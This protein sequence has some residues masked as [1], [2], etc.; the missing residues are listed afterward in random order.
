MKNIFRSLVTF[1]FLN[2]L[3]GIN[4]SSVNISDDELNLSRSF[5][6]ESMQSV[7]IHEDEES[8]NVMD[9]VGDNLQASDSEY[10][11]R[12]QSYHE[13]NYGTDNNSNGSNVIQ[14][15][16]PSLLPQNYDQETLSTED[17]GAGLGINY[18]FISGLSSDSE[19]SSRGNH[20][21]DLTRGC[22]LG[23]ARA[24][25]L[26]DLL[27]NEKNSVT[28]SAPK[29]RK[30]FGAEVSPRSKPIKTLDTQINQNSKVSKFSRSWFKQKIKSNKKIAIGLA[31]TSIFSALLGL[32]YKY[33]KPFKD[34]ADKY[35]VN[36]TKSAYT[37]A[38]LRIASI[39]QK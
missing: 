19:L 4:A 27:I 25:S 28:D 6:D 14:S 29:L 10:L 22:I 20:V 12:L 11:A 33:N 36:P 1:L 31:G 23:R 34:F 18:P 15:T 35:V 13:A 32:A 37:R 8:V 7:V 39:T 16:A 24:N 21:E 3:I 9:N 26:P 30:S 2:F 38:K 5:V 17:N